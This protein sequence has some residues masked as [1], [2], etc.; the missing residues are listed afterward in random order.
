MIRKILIANRGE[1]A[2]RVIRACKEMGIKTVAVYST[3][4]KEALHVELA[5]ES[6]CI[7]GPRARDS[8]LNMSNIISAA[9]LTGCDAIHPG[10]GFLSENSKFARLVKKCGLEFIGPSPDVI[11]KM[12]NKSEARKI[13]IKA[14]VPVVPGSKGVV[15]SVEE[16]LKIA[17]SIGYPVLI[18]A[19]N[20]GGG[21]GMRIADSHDTFS[22]AFYTAKAEAK[23]NFGDDDVYVEK[24]IVNPKHVE[25]QIVG[26]KHGNVCHLFERDC[27]IQRRRQKMM[28]EAPCF[29][30]SEECKKSLYEDA[31]K[32]SRAVKYDSV[33]TIE[34]L[35]DK[36]E[37]YYFIEMNTRIQ[38]EH[39]IS[40]IISGVDIVKTQI[41]IAMGLKLQF[42]Q[43]DLHVN[44][45]ALECR[46][47]AED[48]KHDFAP[49]PGKIEFMHLPGGNGIRIDSACYSGYE[50]SP[51]Y[52]SMILKIICYAPTR[53]E[54]IRKM[55]RALEELI[56]DGVNTNADYLYWI[57]HSP[58][59]IGGSY[60][61][62]FI[63]KFQKE[64]NDGARQLYREEE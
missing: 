2:V 21:K 4:D 27:S 59:F 36:D 47:N 61:T 15:S 39:P 6:V 22:D 55:R 64:I 46:I 60:N 49:C 43:E 41:R 32:A 23:A 11:D 25:V 29:V 45:Y 50:I 8:Y 51:Y 26:D 54:V 20:G 12:G 35:V 17:D 33:G 13:M 14:K 56:I 40:E 7:G 1:I 63:E 44:G 30:L 10:F 9:T 37:N 31:L 19:S 58:A 34:F 18:K 38:V 42:S 28:E 3:A 48:I 5:D 53:L 62:G 16:G 52:D 24:V 57:L